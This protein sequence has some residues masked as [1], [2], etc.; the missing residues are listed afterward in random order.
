MMMVMRKNS[1]QF[2]ILDSIIGLD[3]V[4]MMN[5]F[6]RKKFAPYFF[7]HKNPML[8][9][10]FFAIFTAIS[11]IAMNGYIS[12]ISEA[13]RLFAGFIFGSTRE[14]AIFSK[15]IFYPRCMTLKFFVAKMTSHHSCALAVK[16]L[17][18]SRTKFPATK[19]NISLMK[20][21]LKR[22]FALYA[23]KIE[24]RHWIR[25]LNIDKCIVPMFMLGN[26]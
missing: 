3:A 22:I 23:N 9:N 7:F 1:N 17:A 4:N 15:S 5:H 24:D 6:M 8:Q 10:A 21:A 26:K 13:G 16:T 14:R 18:F 12:S 19:I 11:D 2:K 25:P 20:I